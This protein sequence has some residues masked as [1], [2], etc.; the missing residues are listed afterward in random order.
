MAMNKEPFVIEKTYNASIEKVWKAITDRDDM[1][2]WYFDL[3][4][5]KPEAG[6]K[7]QFS[8]VGKDGSKTFVHLCE[9]KEVVPQKKL[10]Y[11]WRYE[12]FGGN[13]LVTFELFPEGNKTRLKLTHSGLDTF[14]PDPDF[15]YENFVEGWTYITGT[16]LGDFLQKT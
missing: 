1:K 3:K 10:S 11:T 9:I 13:S 4:E 8:G 2:Q 14:P 15:V 7:F 6:F 16:S 5:F 12:G